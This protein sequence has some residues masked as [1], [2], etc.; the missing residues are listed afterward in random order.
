MNLIECR[1]PGSL[2]VS[3]KPCLSFSRVRPTISPKYATM[4]ERRWEKRARPG[5]RQSPGG[6]LPAPAW[7]SSDPKQQGYPL[8]GPR[9]LLQATCKQRCPSG[10]DVSDG[11]RSFIS[12]VRRTGSAYSECPRWDPG[13]LCPRSYAAYAYDSRDECSFSSTKGVR[14]VSPLV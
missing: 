12:F 9:A 4:P 6:S 5:H 10:G 2:A 13:M 11:E 7:L 3:I 8:R 14:K 1:T